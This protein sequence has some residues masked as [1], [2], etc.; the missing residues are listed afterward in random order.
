MN[1][2]EWLQLSLAASLGLAAS[3]CGLKR[4]Q[5]VRIAAHI[6]PGY[7]FLY[8][9]RSLDIMDARLVRMVETPNATANIRALGSNVV[10]GA[11][12]TLD[13]VLTALERGIRL[14]VVCVLNVSLGAD[15]LLV[16]ANIE[17]L[18]GIKGLRIGVEHTATGAVMLDASLKAAGLSPEDIE[19]VYLSID[20]H[21]QSYHNGLVEALVTYEPVKNQLIKTGMK[22]VFTSG[23]IP[24]NIIDVIAFR[25]DVLAQQ[26]EGIRESVQGHFRALE[27]WQAD[28]EKY[29]AFLAKRLNV[30]D[31]E[32]TGLFSDLEL[33]DRVA[34]RQWLGGSQ[35]KIMQVATHLAQTMLASG[36]LNTMPDLALLANDSFLD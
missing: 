29:A 31:A 4:S 7:E 35:P 18:A 24:G 13:E 30:P 20:E 11:C 26:R 17:S 2:R 12:L 27:R 28:P 9:A 36:L 23:E 34:N 10:E 3:S 14:S 5:P 32:I 25:T 33:P 21:I 6:W 22:S 1:R 16:P 15:A 8:L 19:I